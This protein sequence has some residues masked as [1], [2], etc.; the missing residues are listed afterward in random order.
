MFPPPISVLP[1]GPASVRALFG[2]EPA[3]KSSL[4]TSTTPRT[5]TMKSGSQ[6]S[7][8][9]CIAATYQPAERVVG[10]MNIIYDL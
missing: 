8:S 10:I 4:T 3:A 1:Y 9:D 5:A 7:S 2:S 6:Y